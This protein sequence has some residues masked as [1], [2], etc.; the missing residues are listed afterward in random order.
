MSSAP[1]QVSFAAEL[2][3]MLVA[4]SGLVLVAR[5]SS[6]M[7]RTVGARGL[8]GAGFVVL[9]IGAFLHGSLILSVQ[10]GTGLA[11]SRLVAVAFLAAGSL[12]W[13]VGRPARA[14][15]FAGLGLITLAAAVEL[16]ATSVVASAILLA[17]G[18]AGVGLPL[19]LAG[20]QSI[21]TR[22][23]V[24]SAGTLL[25]VLVVVSV[26]MSQVI[27]SSVTTA[28]LN[29]LAQR[30]RSEAIE[31][32]GVANVAAK[33][34]RFVAGDLQGYFRSTI[35][36]PL[37]SLGATQGG[38]DAAAQAAI[39]DRLS[40][41][42][43]LYPVGGFAYVL[44]GNTLAVSSNGLGATAQAVTATPGLQPVSCSGGQSGQVVVKAN[45]AWAVG[46]FPE[47]GAGS[48]PLGMVISVT[49]L[50]GAYLA[51]RRQADPNVSLA[52]VGHGQVL[53][54]SGSEPSGDAL[55]R[56]ATA[57]HLSGVSN[58]TTVGDRFVTV[59]PIVAGTGSSGGLSMVASTSTS[60]LVSAT[61]N[62]FRTLFLIA[63]GSTL[64][65]LVLAVVVG[66]RITAGV[67]RLTEVAGRIQLGQASE[68]VGELGGDEVGMLA[69]AF[70]S[71]IDSVEDHAS[72]LRTAADDETKLRN[73]LEA[74]V[75]GIGDSLVAV[76]VDG[77]V[78]EVNAAA[79]ELFGVRVTAVRGTPVQTVIVGH[80]EDGT[81]LAEL[82]ERPPTTGW[83]TLATVKG[84][85]GRDVNVAISAGPVR[86][87]A[88]EV[89]G[90]VIVLRDLR[91]EQ[92]LERMKTEFLSRVGHEL[93]TPL[94]VIMGYVDILLRRDVDPERA[95]GWHEEIFTG[96]KRLLRIVEM[97]E[98][99]ASSGAG[100]VRLRPEPLDVRSL[101]SGVAAKWGDRLGREH[102]VVRR[103]EPET[104]PI[105][106]DRR[107]L[108]LAL[109]E[110]IDN[111]AKFSPAGARISITAGCSEPNAR[112][113]DGR[114]RPGSQAGGGPADS[115]ARSSGAS[116]RMVDI[117]V[118]DRGEG[119]TAEQEAMAFGDFVQADSSDTRRFGGLGLGLALVKRVVEGHGGTVI[120]RSAPG[121]GSTFI[122]RVPAGPPADGSEAEAGVRQA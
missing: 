43:Q 32:S 119:M 83:E 19:I 118:G 8:L 91:S 93:R 16:A 41:L 38:H 76:N 64:A 7:E 37:I 33:D 74:V 68:R 104:P 9:G 34:A 88:G 47:C 87:P 15:L 13:Q 3:T 105:F 90:A 95:R 94:T 122:V 5:P 63:L 111:A 108:V 73:R 35:P 2:I 86:G 115:A 59:Q 14:C 22:V 81:S 60:T 28:D 100:R 6:M 117:A 56:L 42:S 97:L 46:A 20:R 54:S 52:L 85:G 50:D 110:L 61:Q 26:A 121:K 30:G 116:R 70:D 107:W 1:A 23:A 24:A 103:V 114:R 40:Q 112:A 69:A 78:T 66:E 31:V 10:P 65:A 17:V 12:R 25:L 82:L 101:V 44:P 58:T 113:V 102:P 79:E 77:R 106:A 49:P 36:N 89:I 67:R 27:S 80:E 21:A 120:C 98:F 109:D 18:A 39:G 11:L 45:A 92:E 53:A 55:P 71:M 96:A 62:L 72:A 48:Q 99:F 51:Q 57:A 4:A 84:G 29:R 75:A